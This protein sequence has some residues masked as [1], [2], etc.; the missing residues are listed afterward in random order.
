VAPPMPQLVPLPLAE[1]W[2]TVGYLLGVAKGGVAALV[3]YSLFLGGEF[4]VEYLGRVVPAASSAP[5]TFLREVFSWGGAISSAATWI[6]ITWSE[7]RTLLRARAGS[8]L[9]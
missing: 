5:A 8:T 9:K 3:L 6:S 1:R 2:P 7:L 4:L